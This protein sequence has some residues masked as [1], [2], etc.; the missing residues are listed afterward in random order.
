MLIIFISGIIT[1]QELWR[2]V[3]KN[4]LHRLVFILVQAVLDNLTR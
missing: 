2:D 3:I 4:F 1:H